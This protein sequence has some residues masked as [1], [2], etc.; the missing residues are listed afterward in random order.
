[1]CVR[2][3]ATGDKVGS[4]SEQQRVRQVP[5]L[6]DRDLYPGSRGAIVRL[7]GR[8]LTMDLAQWGLVPKWA[9]EAAFGKRYAY[10][11]RAETLREKPTF[12]EPFAKRRCLVPASGF[13]ERAEG[14]WLRMTPPDERLLMIAGLYEP[15]NHHCEVPT[16]TMVTTEPNEAIAPRHDRMPVL[17]RDYD[18]LMWLNPDVPTE[19]LMP[20]LTPCPSD[21]LQV[22]DAGPVT[23]A[24]APRDGL[25]NLFDD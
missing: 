17:L 15:P 3:Y 22:E 5:L 14:R 23:R 21:W 9:H 1:M 2:Y 10:N 24:P 12:R 19:A 11:A 25:P 16:Y 4:W 6:S 18:Y 7:S 13:Y 8:E 20:L